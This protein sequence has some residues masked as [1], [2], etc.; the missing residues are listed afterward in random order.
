MPSRPFLTMSELPAGVRGRWRRCRLGLSLK[1]D[2]HAG[3]ART[4]RQGDPCLGTDAIAE[5]LPR[6]LR[7]IA[8]RSVTNRGGAGWRRDSSATCTRALELGCTQARLQPLP[9]AGARV[10]ETVAA[11]P[12]F[13]V[14]PGERVGNME[15]IDPEPD[16]GCVKAHPL[17]SPNMI[18]RRSN[19]VA[20]PLQLCFDT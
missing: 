18:I 7:P 3:L 10:A 19:D 12:A 4:Y 5:T 8:R 6:R 13:V 15:V 20:I 9:C 11:L 16:K 1:G 2:R 14:R 17:S